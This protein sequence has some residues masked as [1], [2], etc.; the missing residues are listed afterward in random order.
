MRVAT[1]MPGAVEQREWED[2]DGFVARI[3]ASRS[4]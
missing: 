3:R 4:H 1:L 2:R